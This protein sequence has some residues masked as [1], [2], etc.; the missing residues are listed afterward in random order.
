MKK[1]KNITTFSE[2]L[3]KQYGKRGTSNREEFERGFEAFK[4][5]VLIREA[6]KKA[7]MTQQELA[8]KSDT[9]R[10]YI[11][12]IE[13][14][15]SDIRLSTLMRIIE[16]GLGGKISINVNLPELKSKGKRKLMGI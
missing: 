14:D 3:D 6:R 8:E 12:R 4:L 13:S 5:G 11:A 1:S 7:N 16:M 2:H 10:S 9:Q 15:S